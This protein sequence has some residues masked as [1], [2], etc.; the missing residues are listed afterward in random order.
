MV[1]DSS[2]AFAKDYRPTISKFQLKLDSPLYANH[3]FFQFTHP[4]RYSI[5]KKKWQGKESI[6]YSIIVLLLFFALIRNGFRRYLYDLFRTYFQTTI[7]QKQIKE[8][9]LQN[10]LPSL[11][12][13]LFFAFSGGMFL[14]LLLQYLNLA[15]EL[16]FWLLYLYCV[17]GL[18]IIYAVKFV[19]LKFFGWTFQLSEATDSYIFIVFTTNKIIG[20]SLLPFLVLLSLTYG[21][22]SQSAMTLSIIVVLGLLLYRMFLSYVSVSRIIRLSLFHFFLYLLAFELIPLLLINKVLFRFLGETP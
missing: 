22:V 11:L 5:T 8:Q 12:L 4:M 6:F 2:L 1:V 16:N 20:I 14:A 15:T 13:N 3:P 18:I 19:F 9:L 21:A 7:K 17:L 10:P